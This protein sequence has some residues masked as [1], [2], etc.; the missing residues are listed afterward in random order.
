M[1]KVRV[2]PGPFIDIELLDE[3]GFIFLSE[4]STI[5]DLLKILRIPK[6]IYSIG[7]YTLNYNKASLKTVLENED[8]FSFISPI[9]GG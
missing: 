1:I 3:D 7:L 4:G 6:I 2:F 5:R 8:E 9:S